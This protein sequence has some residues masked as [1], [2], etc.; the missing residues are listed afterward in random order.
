M[1]SIKDKLRLYLSIAC[2]FVS[3]LILLN[4]PKWKGNGDN[5]HHHKNFSGGGYTELYIDAGID[6]TAYSL[7]E[8][9]WLVISTDD[10]TWAFKSEVELREWFYH[11]FSNDKN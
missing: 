11:Y 1:E 5:L 10:T 2:L 4:T 7:T 3:L 6:M 9:Y 8:N